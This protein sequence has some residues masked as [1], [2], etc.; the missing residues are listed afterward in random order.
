MEDTNEQMMQYSG[1]AEVYD[2]FMDNVPYDR[3]EKRILENEKKYGLAGSEGEKKIAVDLGCGTGVMTRRLAGDGF[4]MIG[5]DL[6]EDMLGIAQEME[7][8]DPK[9]ILYTM[10]DMSSFELYG[11]AGLV[12][13]CCDSVNYLL[14]ENEMQDMMNH[15][16][17]ALL[18]GGLFIFDFNTL[19]KY[20]DT[21]GD[22][23]IGENREDASFLW[24]NS[25]HESL[26]LDTDETEGIPEEE[27][28]DINICDVTFFVRD[29]ESRPNFRR[30]SESHWQ[31]GWTY[32][33]IRVMLE[34]AGFAVV[35]AVDDDKENAPGEDA[36]RIVITAR[37]MGEKNR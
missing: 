3:W 27:L 29:A 18:P 31:R 13:S 2:L 21:M 9:G 8:K 16:S 1:F 24:E 37:K 33:K 26:T 36:E 35:D 17:M 20:R 11:C 5:I 23:T 25:F 7:E 32:E 19:H 14:R 34:K 12:V 22:V 10:Q 28:T 30:F 6:S 15:V 4:D